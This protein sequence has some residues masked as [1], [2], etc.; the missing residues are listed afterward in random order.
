MPCKQA[1]ATSAAAAAAT[2]DGAAAT[3]GAGQPAGSEI[4]G[5]LR[6]SVAQRAQALEAPADSAAEQGGVPQGVAPELG[7]VDYE[8]TQPGPL[9]IAWCVTD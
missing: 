5:L 2:S 8:M 3:H 1:A 9:G 7:E 6:Q 4:K